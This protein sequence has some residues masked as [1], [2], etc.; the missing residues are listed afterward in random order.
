MTE[1][2]RRENATKFY[3]DWKNRGN[4]DE[5][6]F[7]FWYEFFE[8]VL[9]VDNI[10]KRIDS[11]KKVKIENETKKI[12]LYIPETNVLIEQKSYTKSLDKKYRQ[13]DGTELTPF[14]QG[15][16]YS[17]FLP[18]KENAKFIIACNFQVFEI[19]DMDKPKDEPVII[20]LEDMRHRIHD[21]DFMFNKEIKELPH[22]EEVIKARSAE[23][24]VKKLYNAFYNQ[25]KNIENDKHEQNSLNKLIVRIVFC[26][27]AE[28]AEIFDYS[29]RKIFH[30][31]LKGFN[32]A[33]MRKALIDLFNILNTPKEKRDPY[34]TSAVSKFPYVN[35]G[36]FADEDI[37]IPEFTPEIRE[38]ILN[39]AS[40]NF[41]WSDISPTIFGAMFESTLNPDTRHDNGMHYTS[42][43]NI[44]KVIDPLFL[45]DLNNEF[46][47]ILDIKENKNKTLNGFKGT[48]AYT[49]ETQRVAELFNMYKLLTSIE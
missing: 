5:D 26:L 43:E 15:Y 18:H 48:E 9:G 30:D 46:N 4:E 17:R 21:F 32:P 29:N 37:L 38:T 3:N 44:H 35:G 31:Y 47:T 41:D 40:S 45:D 7:N 20:T 10:T 49:S 13:S 24:I 28:D 2:Q 6:T 19:H 1:Q 36:L 39:E 8:Q 25:Y 11:Q 22:D 42:I 27:Y 14:E 23:K 34:D 12:D 16:R 33:N